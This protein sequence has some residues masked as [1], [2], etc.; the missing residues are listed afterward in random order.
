MLPLLF[1]VLT[2]T[3]PKTEGW[4]G[5]TFGSGPKCWDSKGLRWSDSGIKGARTTTT[6]PLEASDPTGDFFSNT[7]KKKKKTL[8]DLN[9][10]SEVL[11]GMGIQNVLASQ[12]TGRLVAQGDYP[13]LR[14][15]GMGSRRGPGRGDSPFPSSPKHCGPKGG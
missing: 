4:T 14:A 15:R 1:G 8:R 7:Q 10:F 13:G 12:T 11:A 6:P 2:L 5:M 3:H 9:A